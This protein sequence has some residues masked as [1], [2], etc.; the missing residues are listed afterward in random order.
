MFLHGL[1]ERRLRFRRRTIDLVRKDDIAENRSRLETELRISVLILY[2]NIRPRY[3]RGHQIGGKL[4][5]RKG[6]IE[7][8]A[9]GTHETGF[10]HAGNAFEKNV[11][12]RNHRDNRAFDDLFLPDYIALHL[13]E[14]IGALFTESPDIFLCHHINFL[15]YFKFL[16]LFFCFSFSL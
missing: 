14:N 11:P 16:S 3:V 4:H 1:Q 5:P 13:P 8:A 7:Y 15:S 12:S 2:N 10:S 6:K 9:Q